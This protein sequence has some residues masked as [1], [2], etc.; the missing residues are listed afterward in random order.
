[1][2]CAVGCRASSHPPGN[3]ARPLVG[4]RR[5][6]RGADAPRV[7]RLHR[8]RARASLSPVPALQLLVRHRL[9]LA[10][11]EADALGRDRRSSAELTR[12]AALSWIRSSSTMGGTI[13][14]RLWQ[15]HAGFPH[16]FSAVREAAAKYRRGARRVAL[17]VGRLRRAASR[18]AC[19][20]ARSRATRRTIG[21][22][23]CPGPNY[24]QRFR[25]TCL[26]MMRDYGIN[27]FKFDGTGNAARRSRAAHSTATSTPRSI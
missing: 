4:V 23:R 17:A 27:Q 15:F 18:S 2:P 26:D 10:Y 19:A 7:P 13:P 1:M 24:Y 20:T 3:S 5:R 14:R 11:N 12:S 22:S 6:A 8:A 25:E 9:L 21:A 16:G